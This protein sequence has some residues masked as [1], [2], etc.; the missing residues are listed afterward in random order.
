MSG[1]IRGGNVREVLTR[2]LSF[3]A[4]Q[5]PLLIVMEDLHWFDSASWS[6]LVDVQQK[7]RPLFLALNTRP[8]TDPIPP[9]FKQLLDTQGARLVKLEAMMLDDVEALVC[10]RLGV[11]SVPLTIGKLVR[12]KSEGHPFF[13][14]ELAYALRD[15]GTLVIEN[16]EC[17]VYSRFM[18]F[19]DI[20]LPDTLQAAITNRID[21]LDPSQQLTLKVASVIGRIFALR[22]LQAI[23]PIESDRPSLP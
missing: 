5:V 12:E 14:E 8:L 15:S 10:Q 11:K 17:Q 3:E 22:V 7:V 18:N 4:G 19:E 21:S 23:H 1:E 2:L 6:L 20:T 16:Q 9:E 13:A